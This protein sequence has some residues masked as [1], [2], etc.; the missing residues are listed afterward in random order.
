MLGAASRRIGARVPQ[1]SPAITAL[2]SM[3]LYYELHT[4]AWQYAV[5]AIVSGIFSGAFF[6]AL[7]LIVDCRSANQQG[8][9]GGMLGVFISL[10]TSIGT[11]ILTRSRR[12]SAQVRDPRGRPARPA[13]SAARLP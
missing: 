9:T 4:A 1:S 5:V 3:L 10:G 7:P 2:A 12:T 13:D 6:S 8:I 11:P